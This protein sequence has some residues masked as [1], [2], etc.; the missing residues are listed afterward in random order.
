MVPVHDHIGHAEMES[1]AQATS[2]SEGHSR[3]ADGCTENR[4]VIAVTLGLCSVARINII[5]SPI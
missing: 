4:Q 5:T 2:P 1:S 3:A